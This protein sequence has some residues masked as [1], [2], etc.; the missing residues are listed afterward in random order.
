MCIKINTKHSDAFLNSEPPRPFF[1][2]VLG[3]SNYF[4]NPK[5]KEGEM[6]GEIRCPPPVI[7]F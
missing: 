5:V 7:S 3:N 6:C 1:L 4:A 2:K